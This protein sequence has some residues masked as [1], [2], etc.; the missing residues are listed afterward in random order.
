MGYNTWSAIGRRG[1][2]TVTRRRRMSISVGQ[3]RTGSASATED[4][5]TRLFLWGTSVVA[6]ALAAPGLGRLADEQSLLVRLGLWAGVVAAVDLVPIRVW[7]SVSVSMSFPVTLAAGMTFLP[8]EAAIVSFLGSFDPREFRGEVSVAKSIFN[9]SQVALSVMAGS[10]AFHHLDG[11]VL[12]WPAVFLPGLVA[13]F[14]DALV[15]SVLVVG[16]VSIQNRMPPLGVIRRMFGGSPFHYVAGFLLLGLLAL[17][18]SAAVAVGGIW[19]LLLFLASLILAREMFR[20]TQAA[21][22]ATS[23]LRRK[24]IALRSAADETLRE[25]REE[26]LSVVGE[27]HDEVLPSL[28]KV[29]LMGQVLRQ[30]LAKGRLFELDEDLPEL[31]AAT[32]EAQRAIRDLMADATKSP[33]GASG[34][35]PTLQ[36]L[37]EGTNNAEGAPRVELDARAVNASPLS[38]LLTYQVVREALHNA[39][40]H[41]DATKLS[42]R[43]WS[44]G[45]A[46][47]VVVADDGVG[48]D[49]HAVDSDEHFGLQIMRERVAAVG[50]TLVVE[51]GPAAGTTVAAVIPADL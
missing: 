1:A 6:L 51:T 47:R 23:A 19:A 24:D 11:S 21:M 48:F 41:S 39:V 17:P 50:G 3:R 31:L 2:V 34:L 18:L 10:A 49:A 27:L 38:Q 36:L 35:V 26:R 20:Q 46:I 25:R 4:V 12:E 22:E 29:H 7:R 8:T 13:L 16:A 30:D 45:E 32:E 14:V 42:I 9:R 15:N 28:F 33:I 43:I 40:K 5:V 37:V 44:E